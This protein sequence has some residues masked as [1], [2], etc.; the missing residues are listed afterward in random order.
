MISGLK[1]KKINEK[2]GNKAKNLQ[3]LSNNNF[4]VPNGIVITNDILKNIDNNIEEISS[5]LEGNKAYAVRSSSLKED[6]EDLSFAGL[7][8]TYLNV[9][10]KENIIASIKKCYN[11]RLN[12]NVIEYCKKNNI[13]I[14]NLEMSVIVQEMVE[15][16]YSGIAFT[17]NPITGNDKEF[18]IEVIKGLGEKNVSGKVKP[19]KYIYN[20]YEK[21]LEKNNN[22][23]LKE[24][25][26]KS[27]N[28]Q[29]LNIQILF[30]YPVDVEFAIKDNKIY[31]LQ[32]RPITKIMFN[33]MKK[34]WT[35]ANF[36]DG[37][38]SSRVCLPL[39]ASIYSTAFTENE[40]Y[41]FTKAKFLKEEE[42]DKEVIKYFYGR[43][44]WAISINKEVMAKAPRICRKRL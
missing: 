38:V 32:V 28:E 39:M 25:I 31:F 11:S 24:N 9:V 33:E 7:Y 4:N 36:R 10:G 8:N 27:L 42:M 44:Y 1:E 5:K 20:W 43:L 3:I 21:Y 37:G 6:M 13:D 2:A 12:T 19:E 14:N 30:G 18:V 17:I 26:L 41:A 35:T 15:A 23:L 29:L 34:Q 16:D 22:T 40:I